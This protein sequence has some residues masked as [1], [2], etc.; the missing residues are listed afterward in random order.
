[1][2]FG[3]EDERKKAERVGGPETRAKERTALDAGG[4]SRG[5]EAIDKKAR[6][7]I[8]KNR[9]VLGNG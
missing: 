8:K 4:E 9:V 5:G 7:F 1:M 6:L 2:G 3:G